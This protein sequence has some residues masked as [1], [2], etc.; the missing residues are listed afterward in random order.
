MKQR[1]KSSLRKMLVQFLINIKFSVTKSTPCSEKW[2][3]YTC[4]R[5]C[6]FYY[7]FTTESANEKIENRLVFGEVTGKI[8]QVS[9]FSD[10]VYSVIKSIIVLVVGLLILNCS[11]GLVLLDVIIVTDI[12][13]IVIM[14]RLWCYV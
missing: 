6:Q 9:F 8:I 5:N 7:K 12:V 11:Y 10:T 3:L 13:V 1:K 4:V 2:H 14:S